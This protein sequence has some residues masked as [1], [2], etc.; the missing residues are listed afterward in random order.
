[1]KKILLCTLTILICCTV[2]AQ[3]K[4]QQTFKNDLTILG[5][6][7]SGAALNILGD[8]PQGAEHK[9][10]RRIFKDKTTYG[11][12]INTDNRFDDDLEF[13]LG[14]TIEQAKKSI[15]MILEFMATNDLKTSSTFEDED[16]RTIQI[17]LTTRNYITL[18]AIDS[19]GAIICDD[20]IYLSKA[21]LER[22][23]KL[24]DKTDKKDKIR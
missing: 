22:A 5:N 14:S 17:N 1:M 16:G 6:I 9:L 13:A 10:Y 7:S 19:Q 24:L 4:P 20:N 3:I 21:N 8:G 11:I 18:K 12:L 2:N 23:I 15:E